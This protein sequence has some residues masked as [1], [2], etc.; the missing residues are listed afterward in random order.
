VE[1]GCPIA[2][3]IINLSGDAKEY[4]FDHYTSSSK[5]GW[6]PAFLRHNVN[7]CFENNELRNRSYKYS[8]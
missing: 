1:Q 2:R 3:V 6:H 8:I 4:N 5:T 7:T